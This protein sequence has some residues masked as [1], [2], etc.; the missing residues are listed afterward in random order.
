MH[1]EA[2]AIVLD[3]SQRSSSSSESYNNRYVFQAAN[4]SLRS[5][6]SG[7]SSEVG[8][9][10]FREVHTIVAQKRNNRKEAVLVKRWK[11]LL[12]AEAS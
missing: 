4:L 9:F 2:R 6:D 7:D 12:G 1:A 3:S 5:A 11:A 10:F 8:V